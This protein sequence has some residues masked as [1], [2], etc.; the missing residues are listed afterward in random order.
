MKKL[1]RSSRSL[2]FTHP[3]CYRAFSSNTED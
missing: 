3:T 1:I 2:L